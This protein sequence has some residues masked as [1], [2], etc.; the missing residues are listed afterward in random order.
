MNK[1]ILLATSALT[2]LFAG[3]VYALLTTTVYIPQ[4]WII[5]QNVNVAVYING[6]LWDNGTLWEW[7]LISPVSV[8]TIDLSIV[9]LGSLPCTVSFLSVGLP[10]GYTLTWSSSG[11]T[12]PISGS[13]SGDLTFTIPLNATNG[14]STFYIIA[15]EVP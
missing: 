3:V 13:I 12:M 2:L 7:G 6:T 5:N 14:S 8:N 10:N 11:T 1:K 9:N 4:T 15:E